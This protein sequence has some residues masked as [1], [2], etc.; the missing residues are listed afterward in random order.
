MNS[1]RI[2]NRRGVRTAAI[3]LVAGLGMSLG[4]GGCTTQQ[5]YDQLVDANRSLKDRNEDLRRTNQEL[6]SE[7]ALLQRQRTANENA[8]AELTRVN[9]SLRQQLQ[10]AGV[11]L[12]EFGNRLAGLQF[13]SLDPET[14]R[15]LTA[16]AAQ[17]PDVIRYD[18]ARGMLR[19]ASD[20]TFASGS[21]QVQDGV[22]SSLQALAQIL[23]SSAAAPYE[24]LIVG[25]TDSQKI[26][27]G[28][29]QRHPT[30]MHL[31]AHRAISVRSSLSSM[32]VPA[33][34]MYAAGWGEHRPISAN[35]QPS[36]N[37]P[38]N[39]RVEI[40]LT[41]A[42]GVQPESNTAATSSTPPVR[43][44]AMPTRQPDMTK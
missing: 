8:V 29:A 44:E 39:R 2:E 26:S 6:E 43:R 18:S 32:G 37:T 33:D 4:F 28:T 31:S 34:R 11:A 12:D 35:A 27:A 25:H 40:Y 5:N 41:R 10:A 9:S 24:V 3:V 42:T 23:T 22:R 36:G 13:G 16:L 7:N 38:A 17:F 14:D 21:D 20:V 30:N 1:K 19:F 15:A